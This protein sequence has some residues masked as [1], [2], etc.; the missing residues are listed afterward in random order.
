MAAEPR[1]WSRASV[2]L[3]TTVAA[4]L[5]VA[6][7]LTV[8][9]VALVALV[10]SSLRDGLETTAE[11]RASALAD[12]VEAAGPA[13]VAPG[14]TG[15]ADEEPDDEPDDEPDE[16]LDEI[17]WQVTD[18]SGAVVASSQPLRRA[19]PTD[20]TDEVGLGDQGYLVVT[21]DAEHDGGEYVVSV[22]ASTEDVEESTQALVGPLALGVPL[23]LLLVGVTTWLVATRALAPV[24]RIRQEVDRI[25]GD[26]LDRRVPEPPSRDE[27]HRLARTMNAMLGRLE[28]ASERQRRFVA[29]ASHE[30]RSPLASIRQTAEVAQTHPDALPEGELAEAVLEESARMQ[31]LVDQLLLLTRTDEGVLARD[32]DVDLDD[33]ALD[34]AARARRTGLD[35]DTSGVTACR[36]RGDATALAQVV[37]NLVD[38]A[39]RHADRRLALAVR[40]TGGHAELVV[41]DD[42]PGV[43]E[44][45][46]D[47]VFE[48]FV[49]LDEAR[50]R[51]AGGTGLG[52]AIVREIVAAHGGSVAVL[53]SGPGGLGGARF[54]VRLPLAGAEPL[55]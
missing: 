8:A 39:A 20:D 4:V 14:G 51:D 9:A 40:E 45:D 13:G 34:A 42:G 49:R 26:R 19:L 31:R 3:R 7:V 47:R 27:V 44:P 2:R 17:V 18:A 6:V 36:V 22:A 21:D 55:R 30:L 15:D 25:T 24:E 35:V 28:T 12:Q 41:E 5:V 37:R 46:R 32:H 48:R 11:E 1:A 10:R 16:D 23:V 38:N 54:V 52:L 43:P 29:D 50:A 53:D 33:L